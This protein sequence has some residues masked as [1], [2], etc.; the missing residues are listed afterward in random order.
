MKG[1]CFRLWLLLL[2]VAGMAGTGWAQNQNDPSQ[3]DEPDKTT[4]SDHSALKNDPSG[5]MDTAWEMLDTGSQSDKIQVEA[6]VLLALSS[7]SGYDRAD[8]MVAIAMKNKDVDVRLN[9]VGAANTMQDHVLIPA[10][11]GALKDQSPDVMMLAA[12]SLWK[13][14]DDSG[15]DILTGVLTGTV[16]GSSGFLQNQMHKF[17]RDAHD[18]TAMAMMG[19]QAGTSAL[20]GPFGFLFGAAKSAFSGPGPNSPRVIAA[21]LLASDKSEETKNNF[22]ITLKDKDPFVRTASARALGGFHGKDVTDALI[23]AFDDQKPSVQFMAAA[24]YIRVTNPVKP[25]E[26]PATPK[27]VTPT[28]RRA[29]AKPQ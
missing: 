4:A 26:K 6:A 13:M 9:A 18:P 19:A 20:L 29:T 21:N 5:A 11:Q 1:S 12:A 2:L 27:H 28:K 17:G 10:L 22:L 8:N 16:K 15:L 3:S 23:E 25:P 7:M 24:A 14:H